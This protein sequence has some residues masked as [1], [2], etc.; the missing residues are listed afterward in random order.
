MSGEQAKTI[1]SRLGVAGSLRVGINLG[2][3][4]LVTGK[5]PAGEPQGVA[6][7]MAAAIAKA[8]EVEV[9]F[10]TYATPG[11]VAD[12]GD[13]NEWDICLI[14]AEPKRAEKIAFSKAYVEIEATYLVPVASPFQT[15][16]D[17]DQPGVIIATMDR[18]AYD[19]YL[20][21]SLEHAEL[22]RIKCNVFETF[23]E[24]KLDAMAG[25]APGLQKEALALP[26]SR[27]L[28]GGY[29]SIQQAVGTLRNH[30][31]LASFVEEFV[32]KAKDEGL[33]SRFIEKHGVTGKLLV[34][35][36]A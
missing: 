34:A 24:E 25:L 1:Q 28:A 14:A 36:K 2:N 4:L 18:A 30:T 3:G 11:E 10:E 27:V 26:G 29:T 32:A 17:V 13:R 9:S 15:V 5:G 20:T 33:V 31:E 12:A 19:L 6:P 21:R 7:D 22:R 8:L 16:E 35:A 23:V